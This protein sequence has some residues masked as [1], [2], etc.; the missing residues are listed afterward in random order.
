MIYVNSRPQPCHESTHLGRGPLCPLLVSPA[1]A[2]GSKSLGFSWVAVRPVPRALIPLDSGPIRR[3]PGADINR[4]SLPQALSQCK[5]LWN[6]HP[7]DVR[8]TYPAGMIYRGE[9]MHAKQAQ[10]AAAAAL[11]LVFVT[12]GV[13]AE[14]PEG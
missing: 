9:A 12:G 2:I 3:C 13:A 10:G 4:D 7:A 8:K 1:A 14:L 5:M 11:V 6:H